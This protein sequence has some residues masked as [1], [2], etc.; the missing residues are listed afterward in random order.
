MIGKCNAKKQNL[1]SS[2]LLEPKSNQNRRRS[3]RI[4]K[5]TRI[6]NASAH[7]RITD[8]FVTFGAQKYQ[9]DEGAHGYPKNNS[10]P[11]CF[12]PF[13]VAFHTIIRTWIECLVVGNIFQK[14][15]PFDGMIL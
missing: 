4:P 8:L 15:I 1:D 3:S 5:T 11:K 6:H 14:I 7:L 12:S 10:N 13:K 9:T 2:L